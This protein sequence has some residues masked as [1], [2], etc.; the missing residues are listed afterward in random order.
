[1]V[2]AEIDASTERFLQEL[3]RGD[4]AAAASIYDEHAIL[5]PPTGEVVRG[6]KA[7]ESFWQS[8]IE[9]GVRTIELEPHERGEAGRL[10]YE[11][12][13]YR[14]VMQAVEDQPALEH[15]AYVVLHRQE[16]DGS[17]LRAVDTFNRAPSQALGRAARGGNGDSKR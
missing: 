3:A 15:G 8:G 5:L 2:E 17:W 16:P 9:V 12:G 14:M 7:I 13:R 11:I 4:A 1:M 10:V 6:R